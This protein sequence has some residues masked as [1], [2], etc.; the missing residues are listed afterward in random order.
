VLAVRASTRETQLARTRADFIAGTSHDLRMPLAQILLAG[1]T[2]SLARTEESE[3]A[4][5]ES[6]IVRESRRMIA[7]VENVLLF[8]RSGAPD[9]AVTPRPVVVVELFA[10]TCDSVHLAV[11]DAGQSISFALAAGLTLLGD[12]QLIRQALVNL[13][14][15]A[16]K[17][18]PAKQ[19]IMVGAERQ[20]DKIMLTVEDKGPGVPESERDV[21]FEA[22]ERLSRDRR[23]ER[24]G[25][26]LG[27]AIVR[28]IANACGGRAWIENVPGG[29]ARAILEFPAA[30]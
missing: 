3:R 1:E 9:L 2:L 11:E 27:L 28:R 22:Y 5:L 21:V 26:G 19:R 30:P 4:A 13:I 16:I 14:D 20:H 8:S 23:S 15:N 18:G 24:A 7:L 25:S 6:T 10:N 29:G 17:Y 12:R